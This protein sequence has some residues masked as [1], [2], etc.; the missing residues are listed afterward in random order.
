MAR[1]T[2]TNQKT[3]AKT[4]GKAL[5]AFCNVLGTLMLIVVIGL[6]VPLTIPMLL[7]YQVFD[8]V[9]GSMEPEIPVGSAVYVKS[10]DLEDIQEGEVIA[11]HDGDSV[12]VHRVVENHTSLGEFVT[13]GDANVH[14]DF[15]PVLYES[16]VGRM[17]RHVPM[18]GAFMA[19]YA[20]V[21]GKIYLLIAAA[22]GVMLNLVASRMR[23]TRRVK[24]L[25]SQFAAS[26]ELHPDEG[27]G[28]GAVPGAGA[29]LSQSTGSLSRESS[30][31]GYDSS[32]SYRH[33]AT[34]LHAEKKRRGNIVRGVVVALLAVAFLGSAGVIGFVNWQYHLSD[35]LYGDATDKYLSE[36]DPSKTGAGDKPP[37]NIDFESLCAKNPDVV[38]WIY[39]PGTVINY[40]VLQGK[41]NDDYLHHDYT[42][43]YNMNG[44]IFVDSGNAPG[45]MD[46]NTIVYGHN[47][48][49]GSMFASLEKWGEQ[50]YYEKHPIMWLLTPTQ[51]YKIVLFSG[52]HTNAYSTM[53]Q[54][55]HQP[56]EEL[57]AL[58][59]EAL[60]E[61]G[62]HANAQ[63]DTTL[64]KL[65]AMKGINQSEIQVD[66][67]QLPVLL[68]AESRYVML[69]TCA[70]LFNNDRY[71]LHG[72]L[73]PVASVGGKAK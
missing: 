18:V 5:P 64:A 39:C 27:R 55:I 49:S 53:Y 48:D 56:G 21:A 35:S 22:C 62:F 73:V 28:A 52:H 13:K 40:P 8:V 38:G 46:S 16:V 59:G 32:A 63:L 6:C 12:V 44:S 66:K 1:K 68:D 20:S 37:I 30:G 25:Q 2:K 67:G 24:E 65:A 47:M 69:S 42:G 11:F 61:S 19:I 60:V 29:A 34:A 58:L 33:A 15:E 45:F 14:E 31:Q 4:G 51:D 26:S 10:A 71:V 7:G 17:E 70:Y 57:A 50:E 43:N 72:K 23:E 9:S 36:N 3:S 41:T 54:I